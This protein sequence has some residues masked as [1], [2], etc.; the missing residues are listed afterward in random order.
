MESRFG[1]SFQAVRIHR[2]AEAEATAEALRATAYTIGNH[3]VFGAG[4]YQPNT[5]A[6]G[7]LLAHELTHVVQQRRGPVSGESVGHGLRISSP[8]DSFERAAEATAT[9]VMSGYDSADVA[10]GPRHDTQEGSAISS[11]QRQDFGDTDA[12]D[13]D[14]GCSCDDEDVD[15]YLSEDTPG[16][17]I[18]DS[19]DVDAESSAQTLQRESDPMDAPQDVDAGGPDLEPMSPSFP[20]K[21]CGKRA[22]ACFSISKR[23]AWLKLASSVVAVAALGGRKSHP[24]PVGHFKVILKDKNHKS[25]KYKVKKKPAPMPYYVNFA[26]QVGFH[27]GSLKTE[28]HGCVHL[29]S[30]SAKTFFDNLDVG[31]GVD[32]VK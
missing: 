5:R 13:S 23:M 4:A 11:L 27:A 14:V 17:E 15:A 10:P 26:P 32:V 2:G 22:K 21:A 18:S 31:D 9:T 6:G 30:A 24:T 20:L 29:S 1:A 12:A 3:I 8:G 7:L 19:G 16:A 25:T 28:S